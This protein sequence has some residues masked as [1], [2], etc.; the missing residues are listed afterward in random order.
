MSSLHIDDDVHDEDLGDV[1]N[2][3]MRM[4]EYNQTLRQ[5]KKQMYTALDQLP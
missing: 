2:D 5:H 1:I 4:I 3:S